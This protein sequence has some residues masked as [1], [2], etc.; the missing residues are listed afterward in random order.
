MI[1]KGHRHYVVMFVGVNGTGK[2]T[3][4][5][6]LAYHIMKK[7]YTCVVAAADTFRA[8]AIE[9]REKHPEAAAFKLR[10]ENPRAAP[11]AFALDS[12]G[13]ARARDRRFGRSRAD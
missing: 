9:Q 7:G 4:I 6:K 3:T 11:A 10:K 5:A 8:G 2:T 12:A 13:H 1:E